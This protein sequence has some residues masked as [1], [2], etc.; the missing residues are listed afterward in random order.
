MSE[1]T[2]ISVDKTVEIVKKPVFA[3]L[4]AGDSAVKAIGDVVVKVREN[5]LFTIPEWDELRAKFT[6]AEVRKL[7]EEYRKS[8]LDYY[9]DLA[10]RGEGTYDRLRSHPAVDERVERVESLYRDAV[11]RTEDVVEKVSDRARDLVGRDSADAEPIVVI[12][13]EESP[14]SV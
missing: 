13:E 1:N 9:A 14:A 5:E 6:V 4:G 8:V 10:E 11:S 3:V 7:T 2:D 12:E